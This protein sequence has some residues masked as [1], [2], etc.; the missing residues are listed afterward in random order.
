MKT[1]GFHHIQISVTDLDKSL[2]F[3]TGLLGMKESFRVGGGLVFLSTPGSNDLLTL[4]PVDGPVDPEAGGLQH[5][6]FSVAPEDH[7][8]AVAEAKAFGA[9]V[10]DAGRQGRD[11]RPYAY[12]K[13]PDGYVIE[14]S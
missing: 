9:E 7:E 5:F 14:L 1:A 8:A 3:Y 10:V 6:G 2:A 13:D 4:R 11:E 12:I